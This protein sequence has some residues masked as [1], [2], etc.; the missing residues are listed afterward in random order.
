[1]SR[2]CPRTEVDPMNPFVLLA[3]AS[4]V[5]AAALFVALAIYLVLI[6]TELEAIGGHAESF[7]GK[8]R[9]GVRA[10]E[11]QTGGLPPQ[12]T[13]LNDGLSQIRDGLVQI[14]QNLG[15]LIEAVGRQETS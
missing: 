9:M 13:R 3:L 5:G 10:I 11:V 8:I 1:M 15:G 12:A 7:L 4:V 2:L 6:V 14:D